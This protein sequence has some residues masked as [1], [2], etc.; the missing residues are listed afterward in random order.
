VLSDTTLKTD[1]QELFSLYRELKRKFL[2]Y[3]LAK[4]VYDE[5][6]SVFSRETALLAIEN[7]IFTDLRS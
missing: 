7:L 1:A 3:V 2:K 6:Y 4:T 5:R